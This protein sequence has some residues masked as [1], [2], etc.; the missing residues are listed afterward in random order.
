MPLHMID[1]QVRD[2]VFARAALAWDRLLPHHSC[3]LALASRT[4]HHALLSSAPTGESRAVSW[5]SEQPGEELPP[6]P[7]LATARCDDS[8][9][10]SPRSTNWIDEVRY[11]GAP[12]YRE[13]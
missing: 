10:G 8:R 7:A 6:G 1:A 2:D 4:Q 5:K 9:Y 12:R 13:A 11:N 3:L